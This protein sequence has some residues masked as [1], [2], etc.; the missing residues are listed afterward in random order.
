MS[1]PIVPF[2]STPKGWPISSFHQGG[3]LH[4]LHLFKCSGTSIR[5]VMVNCFNGRKSHQ[6]LWEYKKY[7]M[8]K[9][10]SKHLRPHWDYDL[11][12]SKPER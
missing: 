7:S 4:F 3:H 6:S 2:G 10:I 9:V 8:L 1:D 11:A 5:L 12:M